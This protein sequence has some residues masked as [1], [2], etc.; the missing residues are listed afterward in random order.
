MS[1]LK[2]PQNGGSIHAIFIYFQTHACVAGPKSCYVWLITATATGSTAL[3]LPHVYCSKCDWTS[4]TGGSLLSTR[5]LVREDLLLSTIWYYCLGFPYVSNIFFSYIY[6]WYM[7][8]IVTPI[9]LSLLC[10]HT[11]GWAHIDTHTC[12]LR[13]RWN[14]YN[15]DKIICWKALGL[16]AMGMPWLLSWLK[17]I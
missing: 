8:A 17:M 14:M 3:R 16:W 11:N 9:I 6:I 4:G 10:A 2:L 1:H 5:D 12:I 15:V 7:S 13:I